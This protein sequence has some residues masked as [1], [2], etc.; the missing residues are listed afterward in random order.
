MKIYWQ[1]EEIL[2][3]FRIE[4][5]RG[6]VPVGLTILLNFIKYHQINKNSKAL[7][8]RKL[9]NDNDHQMRKK[10]DK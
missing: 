3:M 10:N 5:S 8:I 9:T 1:P 4:S 6:K 2:G 7:N